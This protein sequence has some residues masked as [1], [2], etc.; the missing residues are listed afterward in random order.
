MA[1]SSLEVRP[2]ASKSDRLAFVKLP[3]ALYSGQAGF[4]EPLHL[5]RLDAITPGKNPF[6]D[7]AE[8]ALFV[9]WAGARPVGRISAQIDQLW[10]DRYGGTTGHFGF[11]DAIDDP[12]VYRALLSTAEGWLKSRGMT[13]ALGP[14]SFSTNEE[15]GLLVEG[16]DALPMMM[17]GY[18]PPYAGRHVAAAGYAKAKDLIAYDY[19]VLS[20]PSIAVPAVEKRG[21]KAVALSVRQIDMNE[22][23][24]DIG[25]ILDIFN[26]A[27]FDNWG[28][29]AMTPDEIEHAAKNMKMLMDPNMVWIAEVD[30]EPAA[31]IVCLPNL[32]EGVVGLGGKL[33]PFGW[34]KLLWRLK[35]SKLKTS[36]VMLFGVRQKYRRSALSAALILRLLE[37][38][39]V[40]GRRIGRTR[41]ELSWILEDNIPM[42][43]IIE[44][45]GGKAYKTY[46]V[47]RKS[48]A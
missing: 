26:D 11:I 23:R 46:R 39:R 45:V 28:Y 32:M 7:H 35:I 31:M 29:V 14:F 8:A 13:E 42:R 16:F 12:S 47:Y 37:A 41:A 1:L 33:L 25:I 44:R 38:L 20:A 10:R 34:A 24:R 5:E 17:M 21:E 2:V 3:G 22:Y 4:V 48:L 9:A 27:W 30:G 6:F 19:D 15:T 43:R 18:H 40:N 36:R